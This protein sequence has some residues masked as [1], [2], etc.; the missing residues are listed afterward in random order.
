MTITLSIDDEVLQEARRRAEAMGTS[1]NQLVR[2][3]LKQLAGNSESECGRHGVRAALAPVPRQLGRLEVQ[4]RGTARAEM[5]G[6]VFFD[7][8]CGGIRRRSLVAAETGPCHP[9]FCGAS[10]HRARLLPPTAPI[11]RSL[12]S[13][14]VLGGVRVVNPFV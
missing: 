6:R 11:E 13:G 3:Y 1:L 12:Q 14:A 2:D 4:P 5:N 10:S 9:A 7:T 8:N